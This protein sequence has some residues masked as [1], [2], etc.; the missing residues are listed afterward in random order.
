MTARMRRGS[1]EFLTDDTRRKEAVSFQLS[2]K[3]KRVRRVRVG[4]HRRKSVMGTGTGGG[5]EG[6][7]GA[8]RRP[9]GGFSIKFHNLKYQ[10]SRR[11]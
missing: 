5:E 4:V 3:K 11:K 2:K 1:M 9:S 7:K 8:F 10:S 6:G